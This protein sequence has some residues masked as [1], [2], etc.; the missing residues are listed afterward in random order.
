MGWYVAGWEERKA[1]VRAVRQARRWSGRVVKADGK[2]LDWL[3]RLEEANGSLIVSEENLLT[4]V[5]TDSFFPDVVGGSEAIQEVLQAFDVH[6]AIVVRNQADWFE[7]TTV[8]Q[9]QIGELNDVQG[10]YRD[11][12]GS[13]LDWSRV[14][15]ELEQSSSN[16]ISVVPFEAITVAGPTGFYLRL[17]NTIPG[18]AES[19]PEPVMPTGARQ[20][21]R[22]IS[23]PAYK[24][25]KE[26]SPLLS[27]EAR[28]AF[29]D[30][31]QRHLSNEK[32]PRI[33]VLGEPDRKKL[34]LAHKNSN[35]RLLDRSRPLFSEQE[36]ELLLN[37]YS[38]DQSPWRM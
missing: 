13:L 30:A 14:V 10:T 6:F 16:R 5:R 31:A 24:V 11:D 35:I 2:D 15:E 25:L 7:S 26:I 9:I 8:W 18:L 32:Y 1:F 29:R 38:I 28:K 27:D 23:L 19:M 20:N 36:F 3:R 22:S 37:F 34:L 12:I 4:T 21:N 33:S 17:L